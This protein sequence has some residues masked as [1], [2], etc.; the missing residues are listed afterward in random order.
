MTRL[1]DMI[2]SRPLNCER[3][4]R[5]PS[6]QLKTPGKP[7]VFQAAPCY[8]LVLQTLVTKGDTMARTRA[9]MRLYQRDPP[10]PIKNRP[11]YR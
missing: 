7:L 3:T 9:E 1:A 10:R 8:I 6:I 2:D 4:L 11:T 5:A